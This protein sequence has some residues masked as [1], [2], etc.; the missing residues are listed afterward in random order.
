MTKDSYVKIR[1]H[2]FSIDEIA[3]SGQCFRMFKISSDTWRVI[4]FDRSLCIHQEENFTHVFECSRKEFDE[5]WFNYFDMQRD[6]G[7][8]KGNIRASGDPYLIAAINY[9]YG[10][11][12]LRQDLWE[13]IVTFLISQRNNIPRIRKIIAKLCEP[14]GNHFP[15]P[16]ILANY[17]ENDFESLGLGYRSKYLRNIT[18]SA[19]KGDLNFDTLRKMNCQDAIGFL[20]C[21]SGIG[22]KVANCIALFGLHRVEAFPIDVWIRR[23]IEDEYDGNFDI[24]RF[25]GYAGIVQQYMFFRQRS[26]RSRSTT[27]D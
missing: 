26:L 27:I 24:N 18:R 8:I 5:I 3:N 10:I 23:I 20:K 6:Y 1:S 19:L 11:R 22:D 25:S 14:Y 4:A 16:N 2:D 15:T 12:I 9:G 21:F 17:T 13:I 7:K